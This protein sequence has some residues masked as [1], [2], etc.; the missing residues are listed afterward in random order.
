MSPLQIVT[1]HPPR[2]GESKQGYAQR[3]LAVAYAHITNGSYD[4]CLAI[5]ER[6]ALGSKGDAEDKLSNVQIEI[7]QEKLMV[8]ELLKGG[9]Q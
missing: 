6:I 5:V 3:C 2:T 7:H 9:Q 8:L 1:A 4:R